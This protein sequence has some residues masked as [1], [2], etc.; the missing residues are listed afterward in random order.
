[1]SNKRDT[2]RKAYHETDKHPTNEIIQDHILLIKK[3]S[4]KFNI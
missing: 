2:E 4:H 1:M 3:K